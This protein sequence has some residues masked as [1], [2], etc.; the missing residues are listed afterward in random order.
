MVDIEDLLKAATTAQTPS[1]PFKILT[2]ADALSPRPPLE[3]LV[4]SLI[5]PGSVSLFA[6]EPGSK[7]TWALLHLACSIASGKTWLGF[8]VKQTAALIIDEESGQRRI[9]DRLAEILLGLSIGKDTPVYAISLHAF[10]LRDDDGVQTLEDA[11]SITQAG[12]V[13]ID[14]LADVAPGADENSVKDMIPLML[15]LRRLADKTQAAIAV[16]HHTPKAKTS[17]YRGTSA[18]AGAVDLLIQIESA[19]TEALIKFSTAKTRDGEPQTFY[20]TAAWDA[21]EG[22][23]TLSE[24]GSGQVQKQGAKAFILDYLRTHQKATVDEIMANATGC[25]P[26]SA[27]RTL[28]TLANQGLVKKNRWRLF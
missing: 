28:Y 17:A 5:L 7:K 18:I 27:K 15:N 23:F 14:A 21:Y 9:L 20:A 10:D 11:I 13:V 6:G 3:W 2:A 26:Q 19:P 4:D 22:T 12:F 8:P 1:R 25:T 24:T 16:I